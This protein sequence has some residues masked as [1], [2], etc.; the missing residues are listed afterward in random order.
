MRGQARA[1]CLE[2]RMDVFLIAFTIFNAVA[3]LGGLLRALGLF[4]P[5]EQERWKSKRLYQLALGIALSL[6]V[7]AVVFTAQA[8]AAWG[9]R[10]HGAGAWILAPLAW[11]IAMGVI[12]AVVDFAEDG[13]LDGGRGP[14]GSTNTR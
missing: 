2:T 4:M 1:A 14:K 10:D 9:V 8:W 5:Q 13:E 7:C 6:P 3:G 12:F 11:L